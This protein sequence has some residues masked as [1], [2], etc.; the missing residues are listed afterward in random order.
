MI[1]LYWQFAAWAKQ[2]LMITNWTALFFYGVASTYFLAG[3]RAS[4]LAQSAH[5]DCQFA[6]QGTQ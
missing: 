5:Q 6:E 1:D 4:R 3:K 2:P